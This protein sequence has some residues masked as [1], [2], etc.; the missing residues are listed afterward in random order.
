MVLNET[1]RNIIKKEY[2]NKCQYCD[3]I[4]TESNDAHIDHIVSRDKGGSNDLENLTLACQRCNLKK[5]N[6]SLPEGIL[7]ILLARAKQKKEKI[8]FLLNSKNFN[9]AGNAKNIPSEYFFSTFTKDAILKDPTQ[10]KFLK[11]EIKK[12]LVNNFL[13]LHRQQ[14]NIRI[15]STNNYIEYQTYKWNN[16]Y[17]E[18]FHHIF[19]NLMYV[20]IGIFEY[21][22][23]LFFKI[24]DENLIT[25]ILYK[26][27]EYVRLHLSGR[28]SEL[29]KNNSF[30]KFRDILHGREI[31]DFNLNKNVG[32]PFLFQ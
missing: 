18:N 16:L 3:Q 4:I 1:I 7:G 14:Y 11:L 26:P 10:N 2:N 23:K 29:I 17:G 12:D 21:S 24:G 20:N 27:N 22:N 31:L 15:D 13:I 28:L 5:S 25:G 30:Y 6:L 32:N 9:G 19:K 8:E